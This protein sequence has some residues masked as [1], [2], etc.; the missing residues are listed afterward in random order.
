LSTARLD[1]RPSGAV[2]KTRLLGPVGSTVAGFLNLGAGFVSGTVQT[3]G[4]A[5]ISS[6]RQVIQISNIDYIVESI[7]L[8]VFGTALA[9]VVNQDQ[10]L[11]TFISHGYNGSG[12]NFFCGSAD[13]VCGGISQPW[14]AQTT[15]EPN[16]L[17]SRAID[18]SNRCLNGSTSQVALTSQI[19][20]PSYFC[21]RYTE[22]GN[23]RVVVGW[24]AKGD[25]VP[26]V[27]VVEDEEQVRVLAES[28][29][30]ADGHTTFSAAST[31]QALALL[32]NSDPIDLLFTDL[33]LQGDPEAGLSLAA[34][35]QEM[36]P[37]LKVIYTSGQGVTDG[38]IALFV[39]NS[40]YLPKPYT[41]EQ[42]GTLLSMKFGF[43]PSPRRTS[44]D[45]GD[46]SERNN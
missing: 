11:G 30:Q 5:A 4:N 36:R 10:A 43:Q 2:T 39:E 19:I 44:G 28:A 38:M 32:G 20:R 8:Q 45:G 42:L 46:R 1:L 29:L 9:N 35:A 15:I 26:V 22:L 24:G 3:K 31:E 7:S 25:V 34:K 40:A 37:G 18:F 33:N 41:V 14:E 16:L 13:T 6:D 27:L 23:P 21:G 12:F 17:S